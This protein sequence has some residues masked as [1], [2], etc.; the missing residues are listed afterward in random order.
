MPVDVRGF[1]LQPQAGSLA[2]GLQELAGFQALG[3]Q[4]IQ[5]DKQ[6]QIR[7]LLG[8]AT[9]VPQTQQQQMLAA[10]T[11]GLG[12]E[13]AM[14]EQPKAQMSMEELKVQARQI[15]PA[16]ANK[17][18]KEMGFDDETKRAEASRFAAQLQSVPFEN[19]ASMISAR[20]Q[21]LQAQGRDP[22]DTIQL[23]DMTEAQQNEALT[24]VQ[25]L[26]LSTKERLSIQA[27]A[28]KGAEA[29][30]SEREFNNLI[31][32]FTPEE[33][34]E[35]RRIKA[36]LTGRATGSAAQTIAKEGTAEQVGESQ[37]IIKQ[38]EKFGE[39]TGSSRAKAI[40]KGVER[41]QNIDKSIRNFDK[42]I[43]AIDKGA[44]TGA[45]QR[46][47]PTVRASTAE[48]EQIQ[49]LLALDVLNSATFGALSEKELEVVKE[50]AMP[51]KLS[52][53]ELREWF[54]LR[55]SGEQKLRKYFK[56]QI[57]HLDQ[58]G[59]VASFLRMKDR[60]NAAGEREVTIEAE[61]V[62][63]VAPTGK[64]AT[65]PQTGERIQEMSD[66]TWRAL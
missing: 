24:G 65:N 35:A 44:K 6:A 27:A 55:K 45:L 62:S 53:P 66:G 7:Q 59:T 54:E 51:E 43:A 1:N 17:A 29:G 26:D 14:A 2:G 10:Q 61:E 19:R 32:D 20:A 5:R 52:P 23:L 12:G 37:A 25:L 39:L 8:Q 42:A 38:R 13:Q 3:Q 15:D 22:K 31:K 21:S 4:N 28:A 64:T 46:F 47:A 9:Q 16:L 63:T 49:N 57:N 41:I 60:E 34:K 36:G 11:A 30:T 40:D 33:Q 18:L 56:E 48:L 50:T 58:G